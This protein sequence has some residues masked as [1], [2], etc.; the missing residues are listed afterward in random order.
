M[1]LA[2]ELEADLTTFFTLSTSKLSIPAI[3]FTALFSAQA[4]LKLSILDIFF[5]FCVDCD[6]TSCLLYIKI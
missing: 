3:I 6:I 2:P 1:A 4:L 5:S